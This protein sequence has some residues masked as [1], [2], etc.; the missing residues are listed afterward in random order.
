MRVSA[1]ARNRRRARRSSGILGPIAKGDRVQ[2][3]LGVLVEIAVIFLIGFIC[4]AI[5]I[6]A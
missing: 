3:L 4:G 6:S 1:V 2:K 5:W